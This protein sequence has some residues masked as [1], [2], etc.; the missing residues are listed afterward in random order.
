MKELIKAIKEKNYP[1]IDEIFLNSTYQEEDFDFPLIIRI[2][3]SEDTQL[4]EHCLKYKDSFDIQAVDK[5]NNNAL[6]RLANTTYARLAVVSYF[7][8]EEPDPPFH[9][10]GQ[11]LLD[12][13]VNLDTINE[14]NQDPLICAIS[15]EKEEL[16][17]VFLN[18]KQMNQ[19][20]LDR[21]LN[22]LSDDDRTQSKFEQ[23]KIHYEK[24][25]MEKTLLDK[26]PIKGYKI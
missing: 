8:K 2:I 11:L 5:Y 12:A 25:L 15:T 7:H 19:M 3:S 10:I 18:S 26:E 4:I 20:I 6:N 23:F 24:Y 21:S 14:F 13:G 16:I 9:L 22:Y 17:D 1:L